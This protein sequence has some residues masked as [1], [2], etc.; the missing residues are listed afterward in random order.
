[1]NEFI[2]KEQLDEATLTKEQVASVLVGI[3]PFCDASALNPVG[4]GIGS[5]TWHCV[6]CEKQFII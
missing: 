2:T 1:M 4:I 6:V 3:C 5:V